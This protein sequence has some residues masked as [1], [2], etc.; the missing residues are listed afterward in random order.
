MSAGNG[1]KGNGK[2]AKENAVIGRPFKK[3]NPGGPGNPWVKATHQFKAALIKATTSERRDALIEELW[4]MALGAPY[5]E[6]KSAAAKR[7]AMQQLLDRIAG[8]PK[9]SVEIEGGMTVTVADFFRQAAER[10]TSRLN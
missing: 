2:A 4:S 5:E 10:A 8:K 6:D 9:E 1:N 7:W 3:G